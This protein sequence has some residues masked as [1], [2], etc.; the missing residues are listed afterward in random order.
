MNS[1]KQHSEKSFKDSSKT[2]AAAQNRM[3]WTKKAFWNKNASNDIINFVHRIVAATKTVQ[4]CGWTEVANHIGKSNVR[5]SF[6]AFQRL[7]EPSVND[8]TKRTIALKISSLH[9]HS[10]VNGL[11]EKFFVF[12]LTFPPLSFV[13]VQWALF[14]RF[15]IPMMSLLWPITRLGC[16]LDNDISIKHY[17]C[18]I[19]LEHNGEQ[20]RGFSLSLL[21][22]P[23]KWNCYSVYCWRLSLQR[24]KRQI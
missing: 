6:C 17:F 1:L 4:F 20:R 16:T 18:F 21:D 14:F 23:Q 24:I 3:K 13:Y 11:S 9:P 5:W 8:R 22:M 15:P 2:T 12:V 19:F 7:L 10:N